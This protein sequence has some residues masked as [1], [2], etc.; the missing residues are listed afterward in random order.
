MATRKKVLL[1]DDH[2][3]M[4]Q[5]LAQLIDGEPDLTVCAQVE[6]A[7]NALD[8]VSETQPDI[9]VVDI[10]L[11]GRDGLELI[12]ELQVHHPKML[13]LVLSMHDEV[14][15]A[16]RALRAGARGYIMKQERAQVVM[17]AIRKVI[18]GDLYLSEAVSPRVLHRLV[19]R[20]TTSPESSALD[21]LSDRELE[22]FRLI[23]TGLTVRQIAEKLFLSNK[24]VDAHRE[25]IKQKLDMKTSTELLRYAVQRA[26]D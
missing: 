5:G 23:G 26:M 19:N 4:R 25:H 3:I 12:K 11:G 13:V 1:V 22:V 14:L 17:A 7:Q 18:S 6:D 16:E 21:R 8:V 20:Q 10:S 9:A 15:Y 2:A 24:T